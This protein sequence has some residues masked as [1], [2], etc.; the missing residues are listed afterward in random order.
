MS[1]KRKS[2]C[3][4]MTAQD[5]M[6]NI[7]KAKK[8]NYRLLQIH[9]QAINGPKGIST[10]CRT[11][12]NEY[13]DERML[14]EFQLERLQRE[15]A[16]NALLGD[17]EQLRSVAASGTFT[18]RGRMLSSYSGGA[19]ESDHPRRSFTF[20]DDNDVFEDIEYEFIED[21]A[22]ALKR[23][24]LLEDFGRNYH[25]YISRPGENMTSISEKKIKS[26]FSRSSLHRSSR[27]KRTDPRV[28]RLRAFEDLKEQTLIEAEI[29]RFRMRSSQYVDNDGQ[30]EWGSPRKTR[31][32]RN[33]DY[34]VRW[35]PGVK[36]KAKNRSILD[37]FNY[38]NILLPAL[39]D[40]KQIGNSVTHKVRIYS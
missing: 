19:L 35:G 31:P 24:R 7:D 14:V 39:R 21:K 29:D 34:P 30:Q 1:W 11:K 15:L 17:R 38:F 22:D 36:Q 40:Q 26:E 5:Q 3:W 20:D 10:V 12:M 6:R 32:K 16:K 4:S 23:D 33:V 9:R 27:V 2:T 13:D 28:K 18:I 25:G 37:D 8:K